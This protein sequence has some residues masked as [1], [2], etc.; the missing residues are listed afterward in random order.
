M[1]ASLGGS[2]GEIAYA[3][4]HESVWFKGKRFTPSVWGGTAGEEQI[5]QLKPA[6]DSKGK[7]VGEEWF[8]TQK[9]E[10]ALVRLSL[11]L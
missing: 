5:K 7:K 10:D 11:R 2:K 8:T 3:K 4:E 6:F 9:V 1:A